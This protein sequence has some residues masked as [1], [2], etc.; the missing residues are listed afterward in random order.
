MIFLLF[1]LSG[2]INRIERSGVVVDHETN[3]AL[4][5][6]NIEIYLK[7]QRRDSLKQKVY[8]DK[9]GH[10]R[11]E[12]KRSKGLLFELH[13]SGYMHY[14]SSLSGKNDTIKLERIKD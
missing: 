1:N 3:E 8:T 14:T 10:F 6:V 12:E 7:D 13:K 2:C 4:E 9:T 5:G 11:V